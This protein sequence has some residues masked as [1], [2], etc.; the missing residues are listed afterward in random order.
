MLISLWAPRKCLIK[1]I[2]H[3]KENG[4]CSFF[5]RVFKGEKNVHAK[6][7]MQIFFVANAVIHNLIQK[8]DSSLRRTCRIFSLKAYKLKRNSFSKKFQQP[9]P[10]SVSYPDPNIHYPSNYQFLRTRSIQVK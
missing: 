7:Q 10:G 8:L 6:L 9:Q 5:Q 2:F 4:N 3:I 1:V